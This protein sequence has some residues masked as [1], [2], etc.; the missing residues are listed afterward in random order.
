M[1]IYAYRCEHCSGEIEAIQGVQDA[2]LT[3]CPAC[4]EEQLRRLI[5]AP[6][7][8]FKGGG[9]YKDLY[10]SAGAVNAKGSTSRSGESASQETPKKAATA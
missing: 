5:S 10:A 3:H 4:G 9:W 6:A 2:P 8:Q 1:P 7:F